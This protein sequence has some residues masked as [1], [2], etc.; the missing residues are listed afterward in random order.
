MFQSVRELLFNSW[1]YAGTGKVTVSL[2]SGDGV[3]RIMVSDHG[4]GFDLATALAGTSS[5]TVS[6]KFGLFSIRERM[7]ALGGSFEVLSAS[8]QGTKATLVLP[9]FYQDAEKRLVPSAEASRQQSNERQK[10][11][12]PDSPR[13][14]RLCIRV[15]LVDDHMMVRQGLRTILDGYADIHV[16]GEA[17][18]GGE[19]ITLVNRLH[20][21]VVVMDLNMP[22]MSGV[23]ATRLIKASHAQ[24]QIVGFSVNTEREAHSAVVTAGAHTLLTKEAAVDQLYD[25]I[26]RAYIAS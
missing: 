9:L 13:Q 19:A 14:E 18:N 11:T 12:S 3:L 5:G 7:K 10:Q 23:E 15:L 21:D 6:S 22:E 20:P 1:K 17:T 26:H 4:A 8:G 16:V 24:I 2:E 25:A